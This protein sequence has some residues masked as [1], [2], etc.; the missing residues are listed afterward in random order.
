MS[1][2][3]LLW[4]SILRSSLWIQESKETKI[5]WITL[6]ALRDAEGLVKSSVIG[7]A[8]AAK[9]TPE[10]CKKSL[11]VLT[12][13]DKNDS[14]GVEEGRRLIEVPGGWKITNHDM[15]RFSTEAKR[16][17]WRAHKAEQRAREKA[18]LAAFERAKQKGYAKVRK[19]IARSGE[20]A[21]RKQGVHDGVEEANTDGQP[22]GEIQ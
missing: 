1:G 5:L 8:D 6:M 17:L 4:S 14:S 19:N 2:F 3:A 13:P 22:N 10:E 20:I 16:E 7:L 11:K 12:S 9:L 15:Y 21:G 18:E